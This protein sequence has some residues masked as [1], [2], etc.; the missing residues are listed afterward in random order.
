MT[1]YSRADRLRMA[2]AVAEG[3]RRRAAAARREAWACAGVLACAALAG[4]MLGAGL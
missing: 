4:L 1:Y 2:R 3:E